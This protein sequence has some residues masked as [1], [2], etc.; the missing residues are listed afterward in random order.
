MDMVYFIIIKEVDMKDNGKIIE[1][2]EKEHYIILIIKLLMKDNGKMINLEVVV[3]YIMNKFINQKDYLI[4]EIGVKLKIIG[5]DIKVIF[6]MIVNMVKED[7]NYQMEKHFK[8][9]FLKIKL[10]DMVQFKE[11]MELK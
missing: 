8:E 11:L 10:M 1:C 9:N 3:F 4:I 6:I 7:Y 2:M 5:L